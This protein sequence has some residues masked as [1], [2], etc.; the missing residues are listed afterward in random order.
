MYLYKV[1]YTHLFSP[2]CVEY[3][4]TCTEREIYLGVPLFFAGCGH[5]AAAPSTG[6][7]I[8]SRGGT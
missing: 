6:A 7:S 2:S 1:E 5:M 3:G 4:R 8:L